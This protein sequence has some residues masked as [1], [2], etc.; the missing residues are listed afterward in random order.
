[1]SF[2]VVARVIRAAWLVGAGISAAMA[3]SPALAQQSWIPY[4][5]MLRTNQGDDIGRNRGYTTVGLLTGLPLGQDVSGGLPYIDLRGHVENNGR[6]AYNLGGGYRWVDWSGD[7]RIWGIRASYDSRDYQCKNGM[8]CDHTRF[9]W[10]SGGLETLGRNWDLRANG[11]FN[12]G[13]REK[14]GPLES[15]G[16]EGNNLLIA[17]FYAEAMWGVDGEAGL[18]MNIFR[19]DAKDTYLAFGGFHFDSRNGRDSTGARI[20]FEVAPTD[21]LSF[22][23]RG[24]IDTKFDTSIMARATLHFGS[25]PKAPGRTD[26]N[27]KN[28]LNRL[29]EFPERQE[30]VVADE[31]LSKRKRILTDGNGQAVPFV[32]VDNTAPTGGNGTYESRYDQLTDLNGGGSHAGDI[33]ILYRGDGTT[34]FYDQGVQLKNNQYL[35]GQGSFGLFN[36]AGTPVWFHLPGGRPTVT[37]VNPGG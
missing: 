13:K 33:I 12:L 10:L 2:Y 3:I 16:F 29:I 32:H 5:T 28:T 7:Q 17:P 25:P 36:F 21:Y 20:R 8:I 1:M 27:S 26:S 6:I 18:S 4:H 22:G 35:I 24:S 37:N 30:L 23:V 14:L 34:H 15:V 19:A 9:N 11:Y 31:G